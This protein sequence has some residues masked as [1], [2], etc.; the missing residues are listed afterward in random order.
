[1]SFVDQNRD[2]LGSQGLKTGLSNS[3]SLK[4]SIKYVDIV[5]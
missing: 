2:Y 1:M 5:N 3:I 4:M